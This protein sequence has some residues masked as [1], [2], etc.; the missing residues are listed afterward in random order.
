MAIAPVFGP[1]ISVPPDDAAAHAPPE[2][3]RS[4]PEVLQGV[5]RAPPR[6]VE[7]LPPQAPAR[8]LLVG[9]LDA[10]RELDAVV[11]AARAGRT[12]SAAELLELQTKVFRYTQTV[13][14]MSRATDRVVG[15][16]K[17]ALA[18]QV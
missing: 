14:V 17:Q 8:A 3:G 1:R 5:S 16:L 6:P 15:A 13:E 10:E 12:F 2:S 9:A 7:P 4:F 11:A 18:T